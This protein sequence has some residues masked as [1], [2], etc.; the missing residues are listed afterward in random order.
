M[1]E[2]EA[3]RSELERL[4]DEFEQLANQLPGLFHE[5]FWTTGPMTEKAWG[6][7]IAENKAL[8]GGW[9]KWDVFPNREGCSR[10]IGNP[11]A[12]DVFERWADSAFLLLQTLPGHVGKLTLPGNLG[13]HGW[14]QVLYE[15]AGAFATPLLRLDYRL[16]KCPADADA[17][18]LERLAHD[19]WSTCS[20]GDRYPT[21]PFVQALAHDLFRSSAEA[22]RLWLHPHVAVRVDGS[23]C[24]PP[25]LLHADADA[26]A[27]EREGEAG[28]LSGR[29][30]HE[31]IKPVWNGEPGIKELRWNGLLIKKFNQP[32]KNQEL[33]LAAFQEQNWAPRID[34]PLPGGRDQKR[35]GDTVVALNDNHKNPGII[36]FCRDG[37]G[38]GVMWG[39]VDAAP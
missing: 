38:E 1:S 32:A 39:L 23:L 9:E 20:E 5:L 11:A 3:Y 27:E 31:Q 19:C 25:V 35:M 12:L 7:F 28:Y 8:T 4:Q 2:Y 34:D 13:R 22:I 14:L 30:S 21:H 15:S 10:F 18:G 36:Y 6:A 29:G 17:A 33:I 24:R 26:D 37:T 16:W